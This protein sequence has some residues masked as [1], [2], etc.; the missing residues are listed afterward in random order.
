MAELHEA[1]PAEACE[2]LGQRALELRRVGCRQQHADLL[3]GLDE[4]VPVARG[5][6]D[7]ERAKTAPDAVGNLAHHAE[8]DEG[9]PP[10]GAPAFRSAGDRVTKMLPG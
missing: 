3:G 2:Q 9:Q 10:R 5:D 8:I 1:H 6:R 4:L 7:D